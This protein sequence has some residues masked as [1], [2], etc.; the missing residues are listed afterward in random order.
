MELSERP[1]PG[2]SNGDFGSTDQGAVDRDGKEDVR[3]AH[4]IVVEEIRGPRLEPVAVQRPAPN[5]DGQAQLVF[6][7]ALAVQGNE[8]EVLRRHEVEQR[9]G[10]GDERRPLIKASV[11]S[12]DDPVDRGNLDRRPDSWTRRVFSDSAREVGL[13]HTA[14]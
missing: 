1:G 12:P 4:R 8:P 13:T 7:I 6:F 2:R 14:G 11:K 3:V 9:T 5:R 10:C